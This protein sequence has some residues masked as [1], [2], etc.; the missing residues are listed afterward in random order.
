MLSPSSPTACF[1]TTIFTLQLALTHLTSRLSLKL[2]HALFQLLYY[3]FYHYIQHTFI[4]HALNELSV[5]QATSCS[6]PVYVLPVL[7]PLSPHAIHHLS[8]N[9]PSVSQG[10]D[11]S[12]D[13]V[14]GL[15]D[16]DVT[17]GYCVSDENVTYAILIKYKTLSDG[18]V[19]T[20]PL[21]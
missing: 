14:V 18:E 17:I 5:S 6:L 11:Q 3:L 10:P 20:C 19:K 7:S 2:P 12:S 1:V 8:L 16:F 15:T 4:T 21:S 13:T 9:E